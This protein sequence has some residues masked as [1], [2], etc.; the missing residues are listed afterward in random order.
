MHYAQVV[1][2]LQGVEVIVDDFIIAR[3]SNSDGEVNNSLKKCHLWNLKLNQSSMEF[4]G[5]LFTS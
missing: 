1:E 3:F 2:G 5:H 4:M